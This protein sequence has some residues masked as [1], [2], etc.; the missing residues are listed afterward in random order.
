MRERYVMMDDDDAAKIFGE[1]NIVSCDADDNDEDGARR[2]DTS[3][4]IFVRIALLSLR[5]PSE[6]IT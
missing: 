6:F 5:L 4:N 2:D 1:R 3:A